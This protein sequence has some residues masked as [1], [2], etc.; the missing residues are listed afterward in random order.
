MVRSVQTCTLLFTF[1]C[2]L[3]HPHTPAASTWS[4]GW[5]GCP[6]GAETQLL[7]PAPWG[8]LQMPGII[9]SLDQWMI[10]GD[11]D[12]GGT[13]RGDKGQVLWCLAMQKDP[14]DQGGKPG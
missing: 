9:L 3:R 7:L 4:W 11:T 2:T 5:G 12:L 1:A 13:G 8:L 14:R 6:S 10:F